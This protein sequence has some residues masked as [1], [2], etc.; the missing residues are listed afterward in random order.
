MHYCTKSRVTKLTL[1]TA[2]RTLIR[3]SLKMIFSTM[4]YRRLFWAITTLL[5]SHVTTSTAALVVTGAPPVSPQ[6]K[7]VRSAKRTTT[8]SPTCTTT[9]TTTTTTT[10]IRIR[11]TRASDLR[12]VS[13]LLGSASMSFPPSQDMNRLNWKTKI[14]L[15]RSSESMRTLLACR[16]QA[17]TEGKAVLA[18]RINSIPDRL[19]HH[20]DKYAAAR[21]IWSREALRQKIEKA[22]KMSND[23]H[24]WKEHNFATCTVNPQD[25]CMLQHVMMT[26]EDTSTGSV[27][28]FCE[29]AMLSQP[30]T[31]TNTNFNDHDN[32]D[33]DEDE[34]ALT[35]FSGA[36]TIA[37]LVISPNYR[38]RGIASSLME[39][40]ARYTRQTWSSSVL[41]LYVDQVN[42]GALRLYTQ[43]GFEK[44]MACET[45]CATGSKQWYMTRSLV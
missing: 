19:Y 4:P 29:V 42:S 13:S 3:S 31:Y 45:N 12:E 6:Q 37:N 38:R 11:S 41:S 32:A 28:G 7:P 15:L 40:A 22:A 36:P 10:T 33:I 39:S 18:D 14:D 2:L 30:T 34:C 8:N 43:H 16:Y 27:V 23:P 35:F 1:E 20:D 24:M 25:P 9:S 21:A 44:E 26:A 5:F 17:M